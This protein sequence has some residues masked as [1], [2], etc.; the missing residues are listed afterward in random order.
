MVYKT[1]IEGCTTAEEV[2]KIVIDYDNVPA[3]KVDDTSI[4][5]ENN[6]TIMEGGE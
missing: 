2:E 1:L 4:I 6:N 3:T 5:E